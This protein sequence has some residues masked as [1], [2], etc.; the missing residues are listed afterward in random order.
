MLSS[1]A[2]GDV[3]LCLRA[4]S[5]NNQRRRRKRQGQMRGSPQDIASP[6]PQTVEASASATLRSA[7]R[8]STERE[9]VPAPI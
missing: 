7:L 4:E 6:P 3:S 5:R 8:E 9:I 2:A 1:P